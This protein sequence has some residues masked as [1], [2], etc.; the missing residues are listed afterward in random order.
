[1]RLSIRNCFHATVES[2]AAGQAMT[3]VHARVT[4]GQLITAAITS[5]AATD[6]QLM[7]GMPVLILIKATEIG[8]AR[9]SV[10]R[11]S[12]RN[13]L[14]GVVVGLYHGEVMSTIKIE[15]A[16]EHVLTAA[17]TKESAQ[18][19]ELGVGVPVTA[20]IKATDVAVGVP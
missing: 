16:A 11:L 20:L 5:E 2:V 19:L 8:V 7:S 3:T 6:L 4:T 9:D 10:G 1:M 18:E 13:Q 15:I 12:V 14:P 17:I